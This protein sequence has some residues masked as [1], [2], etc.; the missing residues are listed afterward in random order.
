[1][2]IIRIRL[3]LSFIER[4]L[5]LIKAPQ[6][7]FALADICLAVNLSMGIPILFINFVVT[8]FIADSYGELHSFVINMKP[9]SGSAAAVPTVSPFPMN[10]CKSNSLQPYVQIQAM[11]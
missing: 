6:N 5:G 3:L 4:L 9:N 7:H 8:L 2:D 1:M 11:P 10:C